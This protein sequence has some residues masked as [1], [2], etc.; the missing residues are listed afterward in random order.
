V[1]SKGSQEAKFALR[2][3]LRNDSFLY[4][5]N[6]EEDQYIPIN[7]FLICKVK[8]ESGVEGILQPLMST[9]FL[10]GSARD[11]GNISSDKV[12]LTAGAIKSDRSWLHTHSF[13]DPY[14]YFGCITS[15]ITHNANNGSEKSFWLK[16]RSKRRI[17]ISTGSRMLLP[18]IY[19]IPT[20]Y[21]LRD[22]NFGK[23]LPTRSSQI[24]NEGQQRNAKR[25]GKLL[26]PRD[27]V[28]FLETASSGG[29][30]RYSNVV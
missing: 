14:S 4:K 27:Q 18:R 25:A 28:S 8:C 20:Q 26:Y 10:S 22:T 5:V 21:L 6:E 19:L 13:L 1:V 29:S 24:E 2:N 23:P 12:L 7:V 11:F 16:S 9:P 15:L 3:V 30:R 17:D